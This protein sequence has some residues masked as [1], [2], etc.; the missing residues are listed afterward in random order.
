MSLNK[1]FDRQKAV[2]ELKVIAMT[3]VTLLV[4]VAIAVLNQVQTDNEL[5]GALPPWAQWV[6]LVVT[7]PLVNYLVGYQARHTFRPDLGETRHTVV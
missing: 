1:G 4:G 3:V 7:P 2:V 5:L 6:L